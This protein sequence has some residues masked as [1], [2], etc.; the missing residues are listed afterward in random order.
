MRP[1]SDEYF[2]LFLKF[3]N[4]PNSFIHVDKIIKERV[5]KIKKYFYTINCVKIKNIYCTLLRAA[6]IL[7]RQIWCQKS[8]LPFEKSK[9]VQS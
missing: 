4:G 6:L 1:A 7:I 9:L 3:N 8:I 5:E 2:Q